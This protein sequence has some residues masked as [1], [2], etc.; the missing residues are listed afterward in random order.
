MD[1]DNDQQQQAADTAEKTFTKAELDALLQRERDKLYGRLSKSD[2]ASQKMQSELEE[3]RK[4]EA[5]RAKAEE[6]ARKDAEAAAKKAQEAELSAKELIEQR[7]RELQD[8]YAQQ[9][10]EW[11][12]QVSTLQQQMQEREALFAKEREFQALSSY[13]QQQVAAH[14]DQI[15][16]ELL[17]YVSGNSK[18]EID[19]SIARAVEKTAAILAGIQRGQQ[20]QRAA[21][22]GVSTG[23]FTPAGPLEGAG[24]PQ[25]FT[26]EQLKNMSAAE[27]AKVRS[28]LINSGGQGVGLFG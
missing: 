1:D 14:Q 25:G 8:Q 5:T 11:A 23:G 17:D 27:Y 24:Q 4:A 3:L 12:N 13:A 26:E 19:A 21:M 9:Q 16:P 22:P 7:S 15:A 20:A 6:K 28:Q 2:E 18:E 10:E